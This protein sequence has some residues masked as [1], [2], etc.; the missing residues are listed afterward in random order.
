MSLANTPH[1]GTNNTYVFTLC[2]LAR[3]SDLPLSAIQFSSDIPRPGW[4]HTE[5]HYVLLSHLSHPDHQCH[6]WYSNWARL[7]PNGTSLELF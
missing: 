2:R 6:I 3:R 5:A 4:L 7:A 1:F